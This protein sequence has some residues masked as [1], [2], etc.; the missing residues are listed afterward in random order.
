[1]NQKEEVIEALQY[2]RHDW[3]NRLQLIKGNIALK[4]IDRVEQLIDEIT[5]QMRSESVL[6][7]LSAV[8]LTHLLLTYN[9]SANRFQLQYELDIDPQRVMIDDKLVTSLLNRLF[10]KLNEHCNE[11]SDNLLKLELIG[12]N[13]QLQINFAL[14]GII[15]K[16]DQLLHVLTV[17]E[18]YSR[19]VTIQN[20]NENK[21]MMKI[22]I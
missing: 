15:E 22:I 6:T 1:M 14:T 9:W 4:R 13:Q 19:Y 21:L 11:C 12:L 20:L 16:C 5:S 2:S 18:Q 10:L 3:L 7:S 8:E 17:D